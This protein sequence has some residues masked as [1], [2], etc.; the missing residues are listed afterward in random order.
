MNQD[1]NVKKSAPELLPPVQGA[2]RIHASDA[3]ARRLYRREVPGRYPAHR[4]DLG[5]RE[6]PLRHPP[7]L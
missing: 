4:Q 6:F 2:R 3:G 5:R 1:I 7:D